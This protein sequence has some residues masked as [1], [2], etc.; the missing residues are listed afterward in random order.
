MKNTCCSTFFCLFILAASAQK[1]T[2]KH[3]FI[4]DG[5]VKGT[6]NSTVY[7][8]Y[9]DDKG[10]FLIDSAV[11]KNNQFR[12][13]GFINGPTITFLSTDKKSLPQD[14]D[15]DAMKA[16]GKT[17]ILFFLEPKTVKVDIQLPNI[18][19]GLFTGSYT[20]TQYSGYT[21]QLNLITDLYKAENDSL[22]AVSG[23]DKE[24]KEEARKRFASLRDQAVSRLLHDFLTTHPAS[25]VTA[26][27]VSCAHFNLD[28]L[29]LFY[30]RLPAA[31]QQSAYG[32]VIK[33]KIG[34]KQLVAVGR[35]AP[36]FRQATR[37][38]DTVALKDFR[39][40]YVLLQYWSST[41]SASR[42]AN[43]DLIPVYDQ[44][45][46]KNF[47]ILG[48]SLDGRKT[49]LLWEAALEKDP[50][51]W[52]QLDALKS[53]HNQAVQQY[54]VQ[55]VPANFLIGPDGKIIAANLTADQLDKKLVRLIK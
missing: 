14:D 45:K 40:K 42:A 17:S 10:K 19:N 55:S 32:K 49:R 23:M 22:Q 50:L 4:L 39:G 11:L 6:T 43:H 41:N 33:E 46:D 12:L 37:T 20:E 30:S 47:T 35:Q 9:V 38:G 2:I 51:P 25:Y 8:R 16:D 26:Y 44:F 18:R 53:S 3:Q 24:Q 7:F 27:L 48:I 36:Q 34:Q 29:T 15:V 1:K 54:D 52:P 28:S 31:V 13:K 5:S 21:H